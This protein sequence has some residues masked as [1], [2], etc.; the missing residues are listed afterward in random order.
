MG[1]HGAGREYGVQF[2]ELRDAYLFADEEVGAQLHRNRA[3][4]VAGRHR[5]AHRQQQVAVVAVVHQGTERQL[6]RCRPGDVAGRESGRQ[7]PGRGGGQ[8]RVAWVEP[9][10]MPAR[11]VLDAQAQPDVKAGLDAAWCVHQQAGARMAGLGRGGGLCPAR[12]ED[13]HDG[14]QEGKESGQEGRTPHL[15]VHGRWR[16]RLCR[17]SRLAFWHP[18]SYSRLEERCIWRPRPDSKASGTTNISRNPSRGIS[19]RMA[20]LLRVCFR[21]CMAKEQAGSAARGREWKAASRAPSPGRPGPGSACRRRGR[22]R[23]WRH[24]SGP[25][26]ACCRG[27]GWWPRSLPAR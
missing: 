10:G 9:V 17:Q 2:R 21:I 23:R 13:E 5:Q 22:A 6:L 14:H 1:G 11:L 24:R 20:T 18:S 25:A 8:A 27:A 12:M 19:R 7:G 3:A 16:A 15:S 4:R 26:G